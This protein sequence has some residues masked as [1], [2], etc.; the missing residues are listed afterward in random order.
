MSSEAGLR[1]HLS[2]L[3]EIVTAL[4]RDD[5]D[6]EEALRLFEEGIG[7]LRAAREVLASAE[8]RVQ[9]LLDDGDGGA[10]LE[11]LGPGR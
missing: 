1:S 5:L 4:E 2:R 11:E 8:L 6:L 3:D 9:R 7:H 10:S